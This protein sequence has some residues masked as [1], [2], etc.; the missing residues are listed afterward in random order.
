MVAYQ[1]ILPISTKTSTYIS[2][3]SLNIKE[4]S[5]YGVEN[6]GSCL[7]QTHKYDGFILL[8]ETY[9]SS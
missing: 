6:L 5:T 1:N 7:G 4:A 2:P 8:N 3:L 9:P